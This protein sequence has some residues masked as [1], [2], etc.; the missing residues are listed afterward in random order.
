MRWRRRSTASR[1]DCTIPDKTWTVARAVICDSRHRES[2][3]RGVNCRAMTSQ[4]KSRAAWLQ[5]PS[6]RC[7]VLPTS[8]HPWRLVLLG[9]PGVG[10][11]T[12][13]DLLNQRLH[14][15]HL[16]TGDVFRAAGS[17]KE[18]DQSP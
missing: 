9:A 2:H 4:D 10:K 7:E 15:C 3:H 16:S 17:L 6:A 18:C 13:A 11:G 14:A 5:G 8:D 12:Q 1:Q